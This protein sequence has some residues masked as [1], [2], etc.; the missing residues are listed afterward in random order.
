MLSLCQRI[1]KSIDAAAEL[2]NWVDIERKLR[3]GQ[4]NIM[5]IEFNKGRRH[6]K[7]IELNVRAADDAKRSCVRK[8]SKQKDPLS[9]FI[10]CHSAAEVNKY[11]FWQQHNFGLQKRCW[12]FDF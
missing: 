2:K 10:H 6:I 3:H 4:W 7:I 11:I 9:V 12:S 8:L 5:R 1:N